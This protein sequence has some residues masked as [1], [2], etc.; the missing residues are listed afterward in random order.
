MDVCMCV[1]GTYKLNFMI[2]ICYIDRA[3][4]FTPNI[5]LNPKLGVC[6]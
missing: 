6:M 4:N 2:H 3:L 1:H 5:L